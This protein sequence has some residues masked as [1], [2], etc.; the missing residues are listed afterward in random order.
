MAFNKDHRIREK[1]LFSISKFFFLLFFLFASIECLAQSR[2]EFSCVDKNIS[3]DKVPQSLI[4]GPPKGVTWNGMPISGLVKNS[5]GL[6]TGYVGDGLTYFGFDGRSVGF[7][8]AGTDALE[9]DCNIVRSVDGVVKSGGDYEG[10]QGRIKSFG[11]G[12]VDPE[13]EVYSNKFSKTIAPVLDGL[14]R[15]RIDLP[16]RFNKCGKVN[17]FYSSQ[18]GAITMC[19]E[20]QV[21]FSKFISGRRRGDWNSLGQIELGGIFFVLAHEIGHA[22]IDIQK[23]PVLAQEEAQVDAFASY[24]LLILDNKFVIDGAL[25]MT[26]FLGSLSL[27]N[28]AADEHL[29]PKQRKFNLMCLAVGKYT[30]FG[31]P[32]ILADIASR[33]GSLPVERERRCISEYDQLDSSFRQLFGRY[34]VIPK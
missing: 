8:R 29:Y 28:S 16:V 14:A 3:S 26:D 12:S 20:L 34:V 17:A 6:I 18:D 21:G 23:I 30:K 1:V 25:S 13:G 5:S 15:L 32:D 11:D 22:I 27:F 19:R 31:R 10:L 2:S 7:Y 33:H 4:V 24:V 9:Y